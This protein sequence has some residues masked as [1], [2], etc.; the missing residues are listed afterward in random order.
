MDNENIAQEVPEEQPAQTAK[1]ERQI[2]TS[3]PS[4]PIMPSIA[5]VKQ[6]VSAKG[7]INP[8]SKKDI[9]IITEKA[10]ATLSMKLSTCVQYG[11]LKLSF[12]K[13]YLPGELYH[14]YTY[15]DQANS[16]LLIFGSPPL[17]Q[18]L[19]SDLN[20]KILPNERDFAM[21]LKNNYGLNPNSADKAAKIF[22]ENARN[23]NLIDNNNRLKYIIKETNTSV[24]SDGEQGGNG[25]GIAQHEAASQQTNSNFSTPPNTGLFKLPIQ[26]PGDDERVVYFEY[27]KTLTKRDFKV[28]AKALTFVASSLIADD[29]NE[30][31][32]LTIE[33]KEHGSKKVMM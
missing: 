21:H 26:L 7:E 6:V 17:Y 22:L 14:K 32:E 4:E 30:D 28:I 2:Q 18:K 29:D 1:G 3:Y 25:N 16:L 5:L 33:V 31:Y 11:L 27:P 20:G 15:E 23:L 9:S 24:L 12:G 13:G 10:E 19:I 8:I